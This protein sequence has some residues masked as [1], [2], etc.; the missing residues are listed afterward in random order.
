MKKIIILLLLLLLS[1][2]FLFPETIRIGYF[3]FEPYVISQ[4]KNKPPGG[5]IGEYWQ[6]YLLPQMKVDVE[7]VGPLPL[8]RLLKYF[9]EEKL[10]ALLLFP[11][12]GE[13]AAKHL[14]PK[15]PFMTGRPG[16]SFL[17][18]NPLEKISGKEDLFNLEISYVRGGFLPSFLE[19][20]YITIDYTT[21][22][23]FLEVNL[24]KLKNKRVDAVFSLDIIT[25]RY[26]ADKRSYGNQIKSLL[27]PIKPVEF[28]TVF[29]GT[30]QGQKFLILYEPINKKLYEEDI[31]D[32]LANKYIPKNYQ[33]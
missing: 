23:K 11:M 4:G 25:N 16:L 5:P 22:E 20:E 33:R 6:S 15:S 27:L 3:H 14:Y 13:L 17:I 2:S 7:W 1:V 24:E 30:P 9:N 18:E 31:F 12:T 29:A 8:L 21:K 32:S 19:S 28:F 26:E 10:D